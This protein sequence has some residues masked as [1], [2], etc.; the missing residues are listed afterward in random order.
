MMA[1]REDKNRLM[2]KLKVNESNNK[3]F[4]AANNDAKRKQKLITYK[5]R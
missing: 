5:N 3:K 4:N 2:D 1:M